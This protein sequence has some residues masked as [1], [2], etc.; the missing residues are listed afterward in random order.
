VVRVVLVVPV[1]GFLLVLVTDLVCCRAG[2]LRRRSMR[3]GL[4]AVVVWVVRGML[5]ELIESLD[6]LVYRRVEMFYL[7]NV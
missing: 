7:F 5:V 2:R 6:G 4:R 1:I 3:E